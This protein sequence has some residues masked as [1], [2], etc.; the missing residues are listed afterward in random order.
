MSVAPFYT[1]HR[2]PY[3]F[4]VLRRASRKRYKFTSEVLKGEMDGEDV[5]SEAWALIDDPRDT[6][7]TVCVWSTREEQFVMT[8]GKVE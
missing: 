5:E 6:I 2:G 3:V 7:V 8:F 4:L 1:R